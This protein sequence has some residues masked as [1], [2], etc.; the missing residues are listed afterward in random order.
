MPLNPSE[1][2]ER[3]RAQAIDLSRAWRHHYLGIEHLFAAACR[4]DG[5]CG[6]ALSGAGIPVSELEEAILELV[7]LGD[8]A[9]L[10]DGIPETPRLRR[11]MKTMVSEEAESVRALRIEP[12]HL[13]TATLR[14]GRS[15][16]CRILRA[17]GVDLDALRTQLLTGRSNAVAS[18]SRQGNTPGSRV[19]GQASPKDPKKEGKE[20]LLDKF[21]RDLVALARQGKVDPVVGRQ[22]EIRRTMQILTRKTK[23]N[24]VLI[25]EAGVG[26]TAVAYGLALRIAQGTVPDALKGSRL[27][28]LNLTSMVAGARHR[29]EFEERLQ[30]V[31]EELTA[32]PS[33]IVF[34]DE[35][36][37]IVGAGDSRGGMDAGN[38]MKPALAR[39]D[40][41]VMGATTTDEYRS[42]IEKDPALERRFQ[43]V[44][45][46]EPSEEDALEILK[47]LRPRYEQHHG[48]S[49][50]DEV[51]LAAVKLSVRFLPERN[52]PDKAIDLIDE[53][54]ARVKTRS[55]VF[56][57][58]ASTC[59]EV[60]EDVVAEV[61]AD[62]TGI[63]VSRITS[64]EEARLLDME[65]LLRGRVVG[66]DHA[67]GA[68]ARTIR[69]IRVGLAS[70][71]RPGGVFL[72][73]GP[74]GVGK[75]ELA[76]ALAEFLFGSE[77]E[78]VRLDMSEFHDKHS[79]ARLVGAPPGYV[80]YEGE[81]QLTRAVRTRPFCVLL[82]DEA[83]PD[84]FDIFLQVF[85]DGRLTD[86]KGRTVNFTNSIIIMTSNLGSRAAAQQARNPSTPVAAAGEATP[87]AP[88]LTAPPTDV[89]FVGQLDS[90]P[91]V[92]QNA[93]RGHFRPEFLNRIDE[94]VVFRTLQRE[95]LRGIVQLNLDRQIRRI[96]DS[97]QIE[98]ELT[99][100]AVEF[101][102]TK[103]YHPEFGARPLQR[104]INTWLTKPFAEEIL[105]SQIPPGAHV[106]VLQAGEGLRFESYVPGYVGET[107]GGTP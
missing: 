85:D 7:P 84:V 42:N 97:R 18:A 65:N 87:P 79:I 77:R 80:G 62:W 60:T 59:F 15:V 40:F 13:L 20:K 98:L 2:T 11:L 32:D 96:Q 52:L 23:S 64:E 37:Q 54:A 94:I 5:A 100:E 22:D 16:P 107:L 30:G 82:L 90:M 70:P 102:L 104:A 21:G 86:A 28:E 78:M 99:Q 4:L 39:G 95:D 43:P 46:S 93:L 24:P 29:G 14:E 55:G 10:W 34:I 35:I 68:V 31:M 75:T 25:G 44:M 19:A 83:H 61:V 27:V 63:P 57:P 73:M 103:G 9:P 105:R 12:V 89:G 33:V 8:E 50:P 69:V 91:V 88:R 66:Q 51:L 53:S 1:N 71:N 26:K 81:G 47:G 74:S 6:A 48:V 49:F 3:V 67:V 36:H 58:G 17:R 45:V 101:L 106:R 92:Y 72:F 56:A 38:I 76:K 41:A